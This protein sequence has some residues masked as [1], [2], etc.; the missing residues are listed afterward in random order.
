MNAGAITGI[1]VACLAVLF[2][3]VTV[4]YKSIRYIR[5]E[6]DKEEGDSAQPNVSG[7]HDHVIAF[8]LPR[9]DSPN[10]HSKTHRTKAKMSFA[11]TPVTT[12]AVV[13]LEPGNPFE[14]HEPRPRYVGVTPGYLRKSTRR[15]RKSKRR[16]R[17]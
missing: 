7:L 10:T 14:D 16:S 12:M 13:D 3:I 1:V 15:L 8:T 4:V 9:V 11:P 2:L 17:V 5:R 6:L